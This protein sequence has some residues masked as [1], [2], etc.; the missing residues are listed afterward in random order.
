LFL[1]RD[2]PPWAPQKSSLPLPPI[3]AEAGPS[4]LLAQLEPCRKCRARD[5]LLETSKVLLVL[6]AI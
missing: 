6:V 2:P 5:A 1:F 3:F 4:C